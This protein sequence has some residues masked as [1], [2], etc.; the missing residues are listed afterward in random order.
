[1]SAF[2]EILDRLEDELPA[3]EIRVHDSIKINVADFDGEGITLPSETAENE[4]AISIC[5]GQRSLITTLPLNATE[6]ELKGLISTAKGEF[7][8]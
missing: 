5:R 8:T 7:E 6:W 1:M 3:C 4:F 2:D